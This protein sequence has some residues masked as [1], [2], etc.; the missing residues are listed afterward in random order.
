LKPLTA[1]DPATVASYRLLGVLGSGGMGR[2]YLAQSTAGR[3]L[4]VKV[5]RAE[6]AGDPLFRRRFAREVAAVRAVSPLFTAAV[7]D[8][9]TDGDAPWL[10]TT[11]IE[12]PSLDEWVA[13]HG[14]LAP[15]AVLL[16]AAGLAEALASIH[17]TGLVHRD[18]K[19]SNVLLDDAGPRI[20]DFGIALD[21]AATSRLTT[22]FLGTPSYT[23]PERLQGDEA[24]PPGDV[25][26]LGATLVYAATGRKLVADGTMYQQIMQ[27]SRARFDL[28]AVPKPLRPVVVRCLARQPK[29]RPTASELTRV[30]V[31]AGVAAPQPGWYGSAALPFAGAALRTLRI[32]RRRVLAYG[33]ALGVAAVGGGIGV[34]AAFGGGEPSRRPD[35]RGAL[36][37]QVSSGVTASPS[38]TDGPATGTFPPGARIIVDR[39]QR[40]IATNGTEVYALDVAGRPAWRR[41]LGTGNLQ[42]RPR[43]DA[44]VV[45]DQRH[46]W[47]LAADS[48]QT[49]YAADVADAEEAASRGDNPNR[50]PVQVHEVALGADRLF[51]SLGTATVALDRAGQLIWRRPR[52]TLPDGR[53]SAPGDPVV[54]DAT[55]LVTRDVLDGEVRLDLADAATGTV[56][57]TAR[58]PAPS[59]AGRPPRDGPRPDRPPPD[60]HHPDG[61]HPDGPPPNEPAWTRVEARFAGD[62]LAVREVQEVRVLRLSDGQVLWHVPWPMPIA[63]IDVIGDLLLVA[64]NRLTAWQLPTG[65]AAWDWPQRGARTAVSPDGDTIVACN[66][67]GIAALD[68]AGAQRWHVPLPDRV[69]DMLPEHVSTDGRAAYVNFRPRP[70]GSGASTVDVVAVAV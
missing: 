31:A 7:V 49:R 61:Q 69:R 36:L 68:G 56:R 14:P 35:P 24:S 5:I 12:G 43:G 11:Y 33:C 70:D 27:I 60:G 46:A 6:L 53:R 44:V 52:G 64:A 65:K 54:A 26:S 15:G 39:G 45:T 1:T 9:D 58:Y 2:V 66:E 28:S 23:A 47:L 13:E 10:A 48:G 16:L 19:P 42:L 25:F 18:L 40:I 50:L 34:A 4:A 20:I 59:P 67:E 30:L 22:S 37:W 21:T 41:Q 8:A 29:D 32:P 57:W 38:P 17:E 62:Y 51:L 55:R 3:R 63:M